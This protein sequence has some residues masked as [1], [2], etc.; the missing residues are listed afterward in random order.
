MGASCDP[1]SKECPLFYHTEAELGKR[2]IGA[3]FGVIVSLHMLLIT[4]M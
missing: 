4:L 3:A 2:W 1:F